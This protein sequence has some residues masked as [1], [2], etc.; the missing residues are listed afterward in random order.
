M[1]TEDTVKQNQLV[2][3]NNNHMTKYPTKTQIL[4]K[5]SQMPPE[6]VPIA[7]TLYWK[8]HCYNKKWSKLNNRD[9]ST[10]IQFLISSISRWYEGFTENRTILF[11]PYCTEWSYN[12]GTQTI[13]A[14]EN[15]PSII[16]ALHELGHSFG[17]DSE[18]FACAFSIGL[19]KHCFPNEYKK[20]TW[21]G[22][23]LT[24]E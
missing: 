13:N 16:S 19:F 21:K 15:N 11:N 9:K 10:L 17:G 8:K 4:N 14:P 20:L 22:H 6:S 12:P 5:I 3:S 7:I 18:L 24:K 23:M 1:K 2:T